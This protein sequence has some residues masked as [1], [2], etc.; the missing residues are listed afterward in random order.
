M[1]GETI[2]LSA[3]AEKVQQERIAI[4]ADILGYNDNEIASAVDL[5]AQKKAH[6]QS[7][8]EFVRAFADETR[9]DI[10]SFLSYTG[11][12]DWQP[13]SYTVSEIAERVRLLQ[14]NDISLSTV[15][16][17]LQELKRLGIVKVERSGKERYYQYDLDHVIERVGNWYKRLLVKREMIR[18]RKPFCLADIEAML[19]ANNEAGPDHSL[20]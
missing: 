4:A 3:D 7:H 1:A 18:Q 10:L 16:H 19:S 17:H 14:K 5:I 13:R 2:N 8:V 20:K 11:A 9:M 6:L 15:S 12:P